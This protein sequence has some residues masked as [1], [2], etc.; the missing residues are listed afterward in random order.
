MMGG[1]RIEVKKVVR[2]KKKKTTVSF[3]YL[4]GISRE[5]DDINGFTFTLGKDH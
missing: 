3:E 1:Q 4:E 2:G 5:G